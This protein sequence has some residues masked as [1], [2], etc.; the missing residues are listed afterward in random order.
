MTILPTDPGIDPCIRMRLSSRSMLSI[1]RFWM[2]TFLF[3]IC[4]DIFLPL[5]TLPGNWHWPIEPGALCERELPWVASWVLKLCLFTTPAKPL[6]FETPNTSTTLG[7]SKDF[8]EISFR[9]AISLNSSS[10]KLNSVK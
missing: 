1:S 2:V 3:P 4:P 5:K 7:F 6:P 8:K 9:L 10:D